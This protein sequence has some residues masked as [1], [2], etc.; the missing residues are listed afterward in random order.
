MYSECT[1]FII[2]LLNFIHVSKILFD[3][4][5][6]MHQLHC[7]DIEEREN[8]NSYNIVKPAAY[9]RNINQYDLLSCKQKLNK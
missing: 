3:T 9:D 5:I 8:A 4:L 6:Y 2:V 1:L 7:K